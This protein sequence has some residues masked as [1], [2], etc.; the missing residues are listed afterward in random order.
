MASEVPDDARTEAGTPWS[1]SRNVAHRRCGPEV[2]IRAGEVN[3]RPPGL[4]WARALC[5]R[6]VVGSRLL[7]SCLVQSEVQARLPQLLVS[8]PKYFRGTGHCTP[9]TYSIG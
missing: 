4:A 7:R 1:R 8:D 3:E 9:Q 2:F 5:L 6:W